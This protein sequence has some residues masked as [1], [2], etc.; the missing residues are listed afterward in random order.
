VHP[1]GLRS[2]PVYRGSHPGSASLTRQGRTDRK[3]ANHKEGERTSQKPYETSVAASGMEMVL[4]V[5]LQEPFS[6]S[7]QMVSSMC[8]T[9]HTVVPPLN[10]HPGGQFT[11]LSNASSSCSAANW[12]LKA[13][14][15]LAPH[16][17]G[18]GLVL[19]VPGPFEAPPSSSSSSSSPAGIGAGRASPLCPSLKHGTAH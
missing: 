17:S 18:P 10:C 2:S 15:L 14:V 4:E 8:C 9:A 16:D 11:Y 7:D 3:Q 1:R 6:V 13:A 5:R 19:P 12:R